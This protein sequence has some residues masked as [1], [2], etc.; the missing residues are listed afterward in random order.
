M[1]G[2]HSRLREWLPARRRLWTGL[3]VAVLGPVVIAATLLPLR[4]QVDGAVF[5]LAMILPTAVG[6]ALGGPVAAV[7]AVLVGSATHNL[8]FTQPYLDFRVAATTDVVDLLVHTIVA[9]AVSLVVVREQRASRLAAARGEQAARVRALEE[10]DRTRTALLGAVSHDLRTPLAAIAAAASE[11]QAADVVFTDQDRAVM[12][13][14]IVE[15]TA[16]LDRTVEN[17]LDAGRLQSST[18][19]LSPEAVEVEDLLA[20][21]LDGLLDPSPHQRVHVC[22]A[23]DTQP[24][25]VDPP[26]AVAALR[27]VLDNAL[28]HTPPPAT[29][30]VHAKAAD[31]DVTISVVDR[32]PGLRGEDLAA[33]FTPF[34]TG[35]GGGIGLGLAIARG[36]V[37]AHG[38]HIQVTDAPEGG[39]VFDIVLPAI[40]EP[41]P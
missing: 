23:P 15:Q 7:M 18:I 10:I 16:R 35:T 24:V 38:G 11:L 19:A 2:S 33:A 22:V 17:L 3:A 14:T 41:T 30:D 27:N 29:V 40:E 37:E 34:H 28:R 39:A 25:W 5:G 32:G 8:L 31:N 21:A 4:G 9:V 6:A 1:S 13:G 20:E 12:A 36:F 26:L